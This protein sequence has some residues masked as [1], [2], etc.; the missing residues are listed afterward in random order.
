MIGKLLGIL[1]TL[2]TLPIKLILLPLK[3]VS[4]VVALVTYAI[5]L[6]V[7]GGLVYLFVFIM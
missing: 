4:A 3:I 1:W 2:I 5:T 7:L 6:A